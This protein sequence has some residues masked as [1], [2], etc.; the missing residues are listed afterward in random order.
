MNSFQSLLNSYSKLR[1]RTYEFSTIHE[2]G[3]KVPANHPVRKIE[4]GTR[5][6]IEQQ[7]NLI[8]GYDK[9][10]HLRE[11]FKG[12][13][14]SPMPAA[15][16]DPNIEQPHA[17]GDVW[18]NDKGDFNFTAGNET[19]SLPF[20][21]QADI[22][23][24]LT[25]GINEK[26]ESIQAGPTD[27]VLADKDRKVPVYTPNQQKSAQNIAEIEGLIA[28]MTTMSTDPDDPE[29]VITD[30]QIPNGDMV[31]NHSTT[32]SLQ[33]YAEDHPLYVA[34]SQFHLLMQAMNNSEVITSDEMD[35]AIVEMQDDTIELLKFLKDNKEALES[36]DCIPPTPKIRKMTDRFFISKIKPGNKVVLSYGDRGGE[37]A[38]PPKMSGLI[39]RLEGGDYDDQMQGNWARSQNN[40]EKAGRGASNFLARGSSHAVAMAPISKSNKAHE[41]TSSIFQLVDKYKNVKICAEGD[42]PQEDL[43]KV[44][45][46]DPANQLQSVINEKGTVL[47]DIWRRRGLLPEGSAQ[48]AKVDKEFQQ[49]AGELKIAAERDCEELK[50]LINIQKSF[51]AVTGSY[52]PGTP[53]RLVEIEAM[54]DDSAEWKE[55]TEEDICG[56]GEGF[57]DT[58]MAILS[59][60][61]GNPLQ[62]G[63]SEIEFDHEVQITD[64]LPDCGNGPKPVN[65]VVGRKED[66]GLHL[67]SGRVSRVVADNVILCRSREDVL[68]IYDK[69]GMETDTDGA[70]LALNYPCVNPETGEEFFII[71][72]SNKMYRSSGSVMNGKLEKIGAFSDK[73]FLKSTIQSI[74]GKDHPELEAAQDEL[75][76]EADAYLE[77]HGIAAIQL[78]DIKLAKKGSS[79]DTID[80]VKHTDRHIL[81]LDIEAELANLDAFPLHSKQR[82]DLEQL[83]EDIKELDKNHSSDPTS[84]SAQKRAQRIAHKVA[85]MRRNKARRS[86][87]DRERQKSLAA[88]H[89]LDNLG[90]TGSSNALLVV[91]F[92]DRPNGEIISE[93]QIR[94]ALKRQW[95]E[96]RNPEKYD[97]VFMNPSE[98]GLKAKDKIV[99]GDKQSTSVASK[100]D[101][102]KLNAT[103]LKIVEAEA[104]GR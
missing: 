67:D 15:E 81:T 24:W 29:K 38:D 74:L 25:S 8:G 32:A 37:S 95:G 28:S 98:D 44:D 51:N 52:T 68:K 59:R 82:T 1:K 45:R 75:E 20:A 91:S 22:I 104:K 69:F 10:S 66:G 18:L 46:G 76:K 90:A 62:V 97:K 27:D 53:T 77:E 17:P 73:G 56:T 55:A 2:D 6:A 50:N 61:L 23:E 60:E 94:K 41:S 70:D 71:P 12:N 103:L 49:A 31:S 21:F 39:S 80:K 13:F 86:M 84:R 40:K 89:V 11:K 63:L 83:Q 65:Q 99:G 30:T 54:L 5:N 58:L 101:I 48:R 7:F 102:V 3:Q 33:A 19:G 57:Q 93:D 79:K 26:G 36:G 92:W 47:A 85:E 64:Q 87:T 72:V 88:Q 35:E 96:I 9:W 16:G 43:F 78:L 42:Q 14:G 34:T 100:V 4:Q